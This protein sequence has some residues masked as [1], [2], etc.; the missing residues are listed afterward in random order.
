MNRPSM[1]AIAIAITTLAV[2]LPDRADAYDLKPMVVQLKPSG[3]GSAATGIITN[4]HEVPI[5]IEIHAYR[6]EQQPDGADKLL[7]EDKDL[8]VTPPQMVLEP[9][10][11][12]SFRMQWVG[13]PRPDHELSFRIVSEQLPI[14]FR[15]ITRNDRT[16][17]ITMKYRYE[18]ALYVQPEGVRPQARLTSVDIVKDADG[19]RHLDLHIRS[20]G[21]MRAILD[22]PVVELAFNGKQIK[23]EGDAVKDLA[24]LNI[25]SGSERIVRIAAPAGLDGGTV[26][27]TLSTDY[28]ILR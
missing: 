3:A 23:L 8:I 10:A 7:P 19:T 1:L 21:K 9:K 18:M 16:A 24:G 12:Q 20:E 11:S 22:K 17:D 28:A 15:K 5:A 14:Q 27:G 4:T 25:L 2:V 6:R 13:D 26:T